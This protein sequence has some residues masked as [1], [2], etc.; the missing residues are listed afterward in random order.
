MVQGSS[1]LLQGGWVTQVV[2]S[3]WDRCSPQHGARSHHL[4]RLQILFKD[5]FRFLLVYLLFMIGYASGRAPS[6]S[7]PAMEKEK[8]LAARC[9][10]LV[11]AP[12]TLSLSLLPSTG[13][14]P[15]PVSQQRVLQ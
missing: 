10:I 7:P 3:L 5:L 2:F 14:P 8:A 9:S 6:R 4:Y 11:L 13:V 12:Q 15:E 1:G